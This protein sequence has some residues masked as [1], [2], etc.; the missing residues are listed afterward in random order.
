[1]PAAATD[2]LREAVRQITGNAAILRLTE[3]GG[4]SIS[5]ACIVE[6]PGGKYFVKLGRGGPPG[7]FDAEADG[8]AA[9]AR[10][11]EIR[12]PCVAGRGTAGDYAWLALEAIDLRPL[13]PGEAAAAGRALAALHRIAGQEFGWPRGNY[14]G[15]TPQSNRPNADWAAFFRDERL[16]PQLE[17]ARRRGAPAALIGRGETLAARVP[18]LLAGHRPEPSLLHG[19]LWSGNAAADAAGNLVLFDPAVYHGDREADL[20]MTELFGG[21]PPQ[22]HA[23]Y[24]KEHPLPEGYPAR[25]TLYNLYHVLNHYNLF[26]GA[27]AR[28]A[29][30]MIGELLGEG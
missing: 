22:F 12:V 20:A 27:Y 15:R 2:A 8:L 21:F 24:R 14:I 18:A 30:R 5:R 17:L 13:T 11:R 7:L 10:C 23:A 19:D 6:T 25:R 4:G 1:M 28:Q 16:R 3:V 9:L 29:E 26:G